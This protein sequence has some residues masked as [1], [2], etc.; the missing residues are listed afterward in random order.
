MR[1]SPK[2]ST[3]GIVCLI[4]VALAAPARAATAGDYDGDGKAD[5]AV[6]RSSNGTWYVIP[7]KTPNNFLVQQWGLSG[8]I[9]V[10]GDY[11]GDGKTDFAVWRPSTGQWFVIPSSNPGNFIVQQWGAP[12]DI[13]VPGDYDGDGKTDFAV[14]RPSNGTWYVIPS[15]T[16]NNF[17]V[18]LWGLNGDMPVPG[19]YDGDH[20]TDFAVWRPSN[21]TWYV[22]PSLT[23]NNFLVQQ[24]G[25]S[26]DIPV[27]GDYD[28]DGKTDFAVWRPSNGTWYVIPTKTPNNFL[29]QQWGV[30]GDVPVPADYDGDGKADFAVWRPSN[31]TWYAFSSAVPGTFTVTQW[32]VST[33]LPAEQPVAEFSVPASVEITT[34]P[35]P[36]FS[37]DPPQ[38]INIT[39]YNDVSGDVLTPTLTTDTGGPCTTA[40]CGS[41][42]SITFVSVGNYTLS[43]TPPATLS[44]AIFPTLTVSSNLPNSFTATSPIEVDPAGAMLI[45]MP[46]GIGGLVGGPSRNR[47]VTVLNDIGNA[48][49]TLTLLA[50]G[51]AC[52]SNGTGG[53]IC[54]TLTVGTQTNSGTTSTIPFTYT[55]PTALPPAPYDRPMIL[56]VSKADNSK[57]ASRRFT[58]VATPQPGGLIDGFSRLNSAYTGEPAIGLSATLVNDTGNSKT[59][60]W[61]LTSGGN[62]CA[63]TCG[64]LSSPTVS[65]NGTFVSAT[66]NY[67]PP[68]SVPVTPATTITA[69]SVDDGTSD[70]ITFNIFDDTCGTGNEAA[71]NGQ[72]AYLVKGAGENRGYVTFIGSF[73]ANGAGGIT[74]GLVDINS[75]TGAFIGLT[76]VPASSSYTLGSDNRGCLT[77]VYADGTGET[78]RIAMGSASGGVATQGQMIKF[79]DQEGIFVRAEGVLMKQSGGPY[80]NSQVNGNYVFGED[81]IDSLGGR[82]A[83]A[84]VATAN[85][86]GALSNF[87]RDLDDNGTLETND[88]MGSGTYNFDMTTGRG[89]ETFTRNGVTTNSVLYFVSP[90]QGLVMTTDPLSSTSAI[91]SGE[92]RKQATTNFAGTELNGS[93]YVARTYNTDTGNGGNDLLLAQVQV[94][95]ASN[96]TLTL[97]ENDNGVM[98]GG[99]IEKVGPITLAIASNG[100]MTISGTGAGSH[101][102][103]FY[104]VGP[105][106]G[107][108]VGTDTSAASSGFLEQQT[109]GPFSNASFTGQFFFGEGVLIQNESNESGTVTFDGAGGLTAGSRDSSGPDGLNNQSLAAGTYSFSNTSIPI[110]QGNVGKHTLAY[111][112]SPSR[113]IVLNTNVSP[114]L[115]VGQK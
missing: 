85:G 48:G 57:R 111:A 20:K 97:D 35:F 4:A 81:G 69:T 89:T 113:L 55:P 90:T 87:D 102:P 71:L 68:A 7:S 19:D 105:S 12:G 49:V 114:K 88:T 36:I 107:F 24:W 83:Q 73:T 25:V 44:A 96:A 34:V 1:V 76:V 3:V 8:D 17:L 112:V 50:S 53:T 77:L 66:I 38:T 13:P 10:P 84:G 99:G 22:I 110:G 63:P 30:N 51:Y 95:T 47:S 58:I 28:G 59:V 54:G 5:F 70:S 31:G 86:A 56:A 45:L 94:T 80:S 21:G 2:I 109:G 103:V 98:N 46:G 78:Y 93:G 40:T 16:P 65:R 61:R 67:T 100:R 32:G 43:Y 39:V 79:D 64:H 33:D 101:P 74:S 72:Y 27:P 62:N 82:I 9:P 75:T 41:I 29:V 108:V 115:T 14:W 52:P 18:Q 60:N 26:G 92:Y 6:W 104:L 23:P 91:L 11:D 42:G 15:K 37:G 106:G